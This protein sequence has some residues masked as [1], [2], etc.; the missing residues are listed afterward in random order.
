[1]NAPTAII[2]RKGLLKT[3]LVLI[4]QMEYIQQYRMDYIAL[5]GHIG[6]KSAKKK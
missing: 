2:S 4:R 6:T 5:A 3:S 1:M